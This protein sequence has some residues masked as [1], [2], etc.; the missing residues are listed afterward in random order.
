RHVGHRGVVLFLRYLR[1]EDGRGVGTR[2]D[3]DAALTARRLPLG[4]WRLADCLRHGDGHAGAAGNLHDRDWRG[5]QRLGGRAVSRR[6]YSLTP[7]RLYYRNLSWME[8]LRIGYDSAILTAVV[9]FL[10]AVA[11]NFQYLM[12]VTG[13]PLL[14]GEILRPL[15]SAQW[16]F[17]LG[18]ALITMVFG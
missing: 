16:L 10:F 5:H 17:L 8:I 14:L 12:G 6:L 7:A 4:R 1:L 9:V 3:L 18:V 13:V 15:E 2:L 11:T